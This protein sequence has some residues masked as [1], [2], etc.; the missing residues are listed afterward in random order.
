[1]QEIEVYLNFVGNVQIPTPEPT[2]EEAA[3]AEKKRKRRAQQRKWYHKK[4]ERLKQEA[5][6]A[7]AT[8]LE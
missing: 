6:T 3:L 4:Q 7:K 2:P 5:L 8:A 1:M